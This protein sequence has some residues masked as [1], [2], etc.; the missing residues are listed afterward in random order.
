MSASQNWPRFLVNS[1]LW[2]LVLLVKILFDFFVVLQP[3]ATG[4]RWLCS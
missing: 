1:L 3:L 2:G 4:E